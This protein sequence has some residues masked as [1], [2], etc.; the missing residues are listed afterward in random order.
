MLRDDKFERRQ[1]SRGNHITAKMSGYIFEEG[2][3]H[4]T[5]LI[6]LT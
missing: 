3:N 4:W 5:D 1:L 6:D 2:G